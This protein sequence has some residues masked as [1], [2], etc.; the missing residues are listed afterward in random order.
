MAS[1][2]EASRAVVAAKSNAAASSY[3]AGPCD[4]QPPSSSVRLTQLNPKS[5][6]VRSTSSSMGGNMRGSMGREREQ[7]RTE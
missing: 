1:K 5:S 2:Y 4:A 6:M 7:A 3:L